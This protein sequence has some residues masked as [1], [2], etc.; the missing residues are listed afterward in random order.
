MSAGASTLSSFPRRRHFA[1]A[2]AIFWAI[3]V[4]GSLVPFHF[5]PLS[6][7]DALGQFGE[8]L[9]RGIILDSR[10]DLV[11]NVLLFVPIGFF[12]LAALVADRAGR[13]R[14]FVWIPIVLASCF[15]SSILI[16]FLQLWFPD[17]VPSLRDIAAQ[18]VGASIGIV[19]WLGV[20]RS[21][22]EWLRSF[23]RFDRPAD[24]V[25]WLLKA[26]FVGLAIYSLVPFNLTLSPGDLVQKYRDQKIVLMPFAAARWN[27]DYLLVQA[28]NVAVF[29]PVGMLA[30]TALTSRRQPVRSLASAL[31][32]GALAA[33][34]IEGLQ[35][36]VIDRYCTT[37][38]M[39]TGFV[40]VALG[41]L[42]MRRWRGAGRAEDAHPQGAASSRRNVVL[43]AAAACYAVVLVLVFCA[44]LDW[45]SDSELIRSRYHEMI[46]TPLA[47]LQQGHPLNAL[48]QVIRKGV[49]FAPLGG[50]L[51]L[52]VSSLSVPAAL[53]RFGYVVALAATAGVA[54]VI[55]LLQ[56]FL[57]PHVPD[58]SDV[59]LC[60]L[61]G[62]LG[63]ILTVRVFARRE[64]A[65]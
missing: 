8:I 14:Y 50:T 15:A 45:I 20:G 13:A 16:E 9:D 1:L 41:V 23:A 30:A 11:A 31:G 34:T 51:A 52:V 36:L 6:L 61:G 35:L 33:V 10:S 49:F 3:A 39:L 65:R 56:V 24:K 22:V 42:A 59:L 57:P 53:R 12:W 25:D 55:E 46:R 60:T 26:Y 19:L 27:L 29:F 63:M 58:L 54:L 18:S 5:S 44:P 38:N 21:T 7:R 43:L 2:A 40:G 32:W 48:T 4:Y 47:T 62:L 17:R 28:S 64:A 37:G